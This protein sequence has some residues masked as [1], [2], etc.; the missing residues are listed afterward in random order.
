MAT[1]H[2]PSLDDAEVIELEFVK[3]AGATRSLRLLVDSGFTGR[4]SLVLAK[5]STDL[6]HAEL[7]GAN[8][9]GALQGVQDR[10]WVTCRIPKLSFQCTLIAILT[11]ISSLALPPDVDGM[12]GLSF[13]RQFSRWGS[14]KTASGWQFFLSDGIN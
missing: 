1:V 4:S 12:V 5:E 2:Y 7:P 14:E 10:A 6:V 8:T 3:L 13:L 11:D 9:I